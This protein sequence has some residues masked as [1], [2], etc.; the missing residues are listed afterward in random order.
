MSTPTL[1]DKFNEAMLNIYKE[2]LRACNYR[3]KAYLAMVV[4][5]GGI[6]TAKKLLGSEEIQS[7]L[8]ELFR[9][10]RLDLTVEHLVL[11]DEFRILF[12]PDEIEEAKR[13]LDQLK[14]TGE[15]T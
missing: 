7:G 3:A 14:E 10:G 1:E 6:K 9:C 2:A 5:L 12:L 11:K 13:R 15:K 8:Y 4:E